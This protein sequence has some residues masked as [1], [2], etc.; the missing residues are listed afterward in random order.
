MGILSWLG[1]S[2]LP[3]EPTELPWASPWSSGD[4]TKVVWSDIFDAPFTPLSRGEALSIPAVSKARNLLVSSIAKYPLVALKGE[5]QVV[6]QPTFLYRTD[7]PVSP[8]QRMVATVDDMF[9]DGRA[10]WGVERGADDQITDAAWIPRNE[11]EVH[12]GKILVKDRPV[13]EKDVLYFQGNSEGLLNIASRTLRGAIS[14]EQSWTQ[15]AQTPLPGI[16]V[17][18]TDKD[19]RYTQ[20]ELDSYKA[21]WVA[22]HMANQPAVGVSPYGIEVVDHGSTETTL[23]VEGRNA[24][25]LDVGAFASIPSQLMDSTLSQSSLTYSTQEGARNRFFEETLPFWMGPIEQR[26]SQDDVV[27]RGQRVRFDMSDATAPTPSPTGPLEA[28]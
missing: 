12:D 25:R 9:F 23:F 28:D 7:T 26:L 19:V 5:A 10:L 22:A 24:V 3:G 17:R 1:L 18:V 14:V 27:P 21:Q 2:R 6:D 8:F 13:D 11:W 20:K 16:E 15:R 4:L